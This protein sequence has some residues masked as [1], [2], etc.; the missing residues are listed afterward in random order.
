MNTIINPK[1]NGPINIRR[2]SLSAY[3][4]GKI[5]FGSWKTSSTNSMLNNIIDT[6]L[7]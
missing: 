6:Y 1:A 7:S 2:A 4:L 3:K 5:E